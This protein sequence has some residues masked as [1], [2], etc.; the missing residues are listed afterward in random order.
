M[1]SPR[2]CRPRHLSLGA[3]LVLPHCDLP[4]SNA[5]IAHS[6]ML[7]RSRAPFPFPDERRSTDSTAQPISRSRR[8]HPPRPLPFPPF[9]GPIE[10]R[11][12]N[13][14][15][16]A[17]GGPSWIRFGDRNSRSCPG[18]QIRRKTDTSDFFA[19]R[20]RCC[21]DNGPIRPRSLS[22]AFRAR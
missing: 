14:R 15:A 12:P 16:S 5:R 20:D 19:K 4:S 8:C 2:S 10:L 21:V 13:S 6:G 7:F 11:I 22:I 18:D 17:I 9:A 1:R 3:S